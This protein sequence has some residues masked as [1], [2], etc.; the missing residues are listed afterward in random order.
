MDADRSVLLV[1]GDREYFCTPGSE[2]QTDL[3]VVEIPGEVEDGMT[4][5][6]HLGT[7]FTVFEPRGPDLFNHL[8]RTG[9]PMM[10]RDIGLIIGLTGVRAG[11]RVLDIGTGTGILAIYFGRIGADVLTYERN[12]SAVSVA[13]ENIQRAGVA[14]QVA[15]R[16]GDATKEI[17]RLVNEGPFDL[18]TLDT[19]D[20]Q[21][22]VE[23]A[24]KLVR[25]G[26]YIVTY[27][28]FIEDVRAIVTSA[29]S[30]YPSVETVET[31]QRAIDV[32]QR[33]TRPS[34]Q[35]VGHTGYLTVIRNR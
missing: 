12:E 4:L 35:G 5:N 33:G 1:T 32:D 27:S 8:E 31:I 17:D 34:T 18:L 9:A 13:R 7:E 30:R 24:T 21:T 28:P 22:L 6:S 10:P 25:P 14:A 3:G 2:L 26:G 20:A 15:I 11:D 23:E 19:G 16:S 29:R